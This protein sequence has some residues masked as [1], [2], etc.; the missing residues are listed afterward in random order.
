MSTK[1]EEKAVKDPHLNR[2]SKLLNNPR[3]EPEDCSVH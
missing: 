2:E 3:F 1:L